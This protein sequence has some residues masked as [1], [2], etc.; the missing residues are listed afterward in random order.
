MN[1]LEKLNLSATQPIIQASK[2]MF[3]GT[4]VQTTSTEISSILE[5]LQD[6]ESLNLTIILGFMS[7]LLEYLI[8]IS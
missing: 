1:K 3:D 8:N 4:R 6:L 7:V 5:K 2:I